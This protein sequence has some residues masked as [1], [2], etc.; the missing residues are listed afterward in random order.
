MK[1]TNR[2]LIATLASIVLLSFAAPVQAQ[3]QAL[4]DDG[5][6]ASPKVRQ[7]LN[8]R[9]ARLNSAPAAPA[10]MACPRCKDAY[11]TRNDVSARGANKPSLT[12][13]RHLCGD[14]DTSIGVVGEGKAKHNV[15]THKCNHREAVLLAC[16]NL[17]NGNDAV[18]QDREK[19]LA[20]APLTQG[21]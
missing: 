20:T 21:Q 3:Y 9:K 2:M 10:S 15:A 13:A 11:V 1:T 12:I 8:E 14:C 17:K 16:C 4:G 19:N 5:I 18:T 6:A 7:M